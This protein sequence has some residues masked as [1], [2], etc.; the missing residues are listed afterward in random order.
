MPKNKTHSEVEHLRGII[1][2]LKA[3]NI[4]L[5]RQLRIQ[6]KYSDEETPVEPEAVD[7]DLCPSCARGKLV[8]L[9][10]G[11]FAYLTCPVC[12]HRERI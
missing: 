10:L 2:Q 7:V 1:K 5:K 9:D 3:E 8:L 12:G 11:K 6:E 4:R